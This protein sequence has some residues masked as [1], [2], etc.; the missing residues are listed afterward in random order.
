MKNIN[1]QKKKNEVDDRI[2]FVLID[3][4]HGLIPVTSFKIKCRV[5]AINWYVLF[6]L[7]FAIIDISSDQFMSPTE[8]FPAFK[9]IKTSFLVP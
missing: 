8:K 1:P 4:T 6:K 7:Y 2:N 9:G 5:L 3:S